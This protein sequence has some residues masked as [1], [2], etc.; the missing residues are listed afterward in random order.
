MAEEH[1][2]N[3]GPARPT[4]G[5]VAFCGSQCHGRKRCLG[6]EVADEARG[7]L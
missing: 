6:R 3:N 1:R 7:K 4:S 5:R 2:S